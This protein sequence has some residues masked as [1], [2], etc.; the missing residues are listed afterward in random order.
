MCMSNALAKTTADFAARDPL[1]MAGLSGARFSQGRFYLQY[2]GL[3]VIVDYPGG[4]M[5][6]D[7]EQ[8]PMRHNEKVLLLQYLINA[9]GLPPRGRWLSFLDLQ[10]GPLHWAPFQREA[11]WPLARRYHDQL[12]LFLAAG[13]KHGGEKVKMGDAALIIPVLPRLS[14]TF[15]LWQGDNEFAPRSMILYDAVA[16]T[17]LPTATLYVLGI[18]AVIRIWFPGDSRFEETLP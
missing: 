6:F 11:L 12:D 18:E 5:R 10:G 7:S 15:I 4:E 16:E 9:C 14:L 8:S 2:C 13:M 3:P 1:S 17:Y